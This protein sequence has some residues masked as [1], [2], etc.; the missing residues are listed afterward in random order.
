MV[1]CF[2]MKRITSK[3][4]HMTIKRQKKR[5]TSSNEE[6]KLTLQKVTKSDSRFLYNLLKQRDPRVNISH[7]KMPTYAQHIKFILSKPYLGW[8]TIRLKN[9]KVGSVYLSH[10]NE[11]GIFTD[12]QFQNQGIGNI[13]LKL[14]IKKHPLP[15]YLANINPKNKNS[16]KFFKKNNFKLIQ[17][18]YELIPSDDN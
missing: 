11:I 17:Y 4:L 15:R 16:I 1:I 10:Q 2:E 6:N 13:A 9:K 18:T 12:K 14:I 7:K 3:N 8:Y 5:P